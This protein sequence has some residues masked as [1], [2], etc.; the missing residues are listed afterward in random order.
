MN[1][2]LRCE[3]RKTV[4]WDEFSA[5]PPYSIAI[6][7]YCSGLPRSSEDGLRLNINHHEDCDRI[8]TRSSCA[9]AFHLVQ[10]GLYDMFS[11]E[12]GPCATLY[13][14]DCD[15]DVQWTTYALMNP[16]QIEDPRFKFRIKELIN[17]EDVLDMSAGLYPIKKRW[18]LLKRLLWVSEPYTD[19]RC[20]GTLHRMDGKAMHDL[21]RE[22][23]R[24]IRAT[25]AGRGKEIEPDDRFEVIADFDRWQFIR[26][27]GKHA[28][29]GIAQ[30][31]LKAFVS[32]VSSNDGRAR[33]VIVRRSRFIRWFPLEEI[34]R[35][36]NEAEGIPEGDKDRWGGSDNVIGSPRQRG[37]KLKED[38]VLLIVKT[39]CDEAA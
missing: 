15:Q 26:E 4:D 23:H 17:L 12:N 7:G 3:P 29:I 2:H 34:C 25:L 10:M 18:H 28:R 9:Q 16:D 24:R 5:Y 33:Y 8:A 6:D 36:L 35:R 32:L 20:D 39:A 38:T 22:T 19:V 27:V 37:S 13:V 30:K 21:L 1:V 11:D 31:G 14:N